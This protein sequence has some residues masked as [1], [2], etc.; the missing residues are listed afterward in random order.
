M[1]GEYFLHGN[2][3]K[4]ITGA[5]ANGVEEEVARELWERMKKFGL[6]ASMVPLD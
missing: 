1:Y 5:I 6:Y 3:E 2:K 4:G